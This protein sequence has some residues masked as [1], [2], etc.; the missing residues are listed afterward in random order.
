MKTK[1][2]IV[3]ENGKTLLDPKDGFI[4]LGAIFVSQIDNNGNPTGGLIGD[5]KTADTILNAGVKP[6]AYS[7]EDFI[8]ALCIDPFELKRIAENLMPHIR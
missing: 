3:T 8:E 4:V 1:Q 7:L 5:S 6:T 2:V